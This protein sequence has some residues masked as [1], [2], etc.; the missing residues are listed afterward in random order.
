MADHDITTVIPQLPAVNKPARNA[1]R[2]TVAALKTALG[3]VNGGT[4]F[5][6][7]RLQAMT[8]N[9]LVFAARSHG[10]TPTVTF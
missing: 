3:T 6:A 4:S 8:F 2:P 1:G 5:T 9:D 7:A 10:V